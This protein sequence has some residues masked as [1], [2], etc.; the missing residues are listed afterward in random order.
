MKYRQI[1]RLLAASVVFALLLSV[2]AVGPAAGASF[3]LT[4]NEAKIG[5]WVDI[6]YGGSDP[7]RFYFSG[8]KA[9]IG[10]KINNQVRAYMLITIETFAVPD[11]L[12]DGAYEEDVHGGKYYVYAASAS[13]EIVDIA[14]F[15]VI[16]GEIWLTPEE[17]GAGDEVEISGEDLRPNQAITVEYEDDEVD[18]TGG[19]IMTDSEGKFTCTVVIPDSLMGE[20][21]I[22]V[23]DESGDKPEA[24]FTVKPKITLVPAEQEGG[25]P[26]EV[27]GA[28]FRAEY[29]IT[30]TLDGERVDTTPYYIETDLQGSFSCVF[31]APLYDSPT[32]IKV[33]ASDRNVNKAEAQLVVLGGI[34]LG[35]VT[36]TASPGNAGM[37]LTIYGA[38]FA[39]GATVTIT[40]NEGDT[41]VATETTTADAN[42]NF[43]TVF[44]VPPSVAGSH[45]IKATDGPTTGTAT[46]I[47]ES[48]APPV[49]LPRLPETAG[50]AQEK[51]H[52]DW[53]DVTDAS[54]VSYTLQIASDIDFNT[55]AVD[56]EGIILSEYT[57]TEDEKLA[58]AGQK[59]YYWR[60]KV[61][62][63]ASNEGEWSSV[64]LFYVGFSRTAMSGGVWYIIYGLVALI[65]AGLVFWFY[66]RRSR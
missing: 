48:E 51:A 60:V 30:L 37:E 65:L 44:T 17:G 34:R 46:F 5:D 42:G 62:D 38:G 8:D 52:F 55:L 18:V 4:P 15:T 58:P 56:R 31:A 13:K 57:L 22:I 21:I 33:V 16:K 29:A 45:V 3:N 35:P 66:K 2:F 43:T 27:I 7:V 50:T 26:V 41:V 11:R 6:K 53:G 39:S 59:A 49:P 19:D 64:G 32:T 28:G 1:C 63:G 20:H 24:V 23:A 54:G 12:E 25:K 36:T 47:M 61:V 14:T 10:D 40:Y 9:D